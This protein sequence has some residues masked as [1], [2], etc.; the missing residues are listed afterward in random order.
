MTS[1]N[2]AVGKDGDNDSFVTLELTPGKTSLS[3]QDHRK[4]T[5]HWL[6][7]LA[8]FFTFKGSN[9]GAACQKT[10]PHHTLSLGKEK[11]YELMKIEFHT[12]ALSPKTLGD[13]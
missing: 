7:K 11:N 9:L 6:F 10:L 8:M 13:R 3:T 2:F 4:N 5:G 12:K 1:Y